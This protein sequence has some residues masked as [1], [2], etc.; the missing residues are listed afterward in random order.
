MGEIMEP[1]LTPTQV[2]TWLQVHPHTVYRWILRGRL[3]AWKLPGGDYRIERAEALKFCQPKNA[4]KDKPSNRA[5]ADR[6]N[7]AVIA[8]L[9]GDGK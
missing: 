2:A 4:P 1:L 3:P 9:T 8:T 5:A 7:A 6:Y